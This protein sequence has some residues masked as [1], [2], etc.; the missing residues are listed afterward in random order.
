MP[1]QSKHLFERVFVFCKTKGLKSLVDSI[2]ARSS[3]LVSKVLAKFLLAN[4]LRSHILLA[5]GCFYICLATCS[6]KTN[7]NPNTNPNTNS[8]IKTKAIISSSRTDC[9]QDRF[10]PNNYRSRARNLSTELKHDREITAIICD[11]DHDWYTV[12]LNKGELV[13]FTISSALDES[14]SLSVYAPRK[15]KAGGILHRVSPSIKKLKVYAKKSGRYRLHV[16]ASRKSRSRYT[17][18]YNKPL[19]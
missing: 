13:E 4:T 19:Y 6:A 8:K 7:T 17:L 9:G 14:P 11:Q 18:S 12:W 2:V 16:K 1:A 15:R 5:I 3:L 10:E